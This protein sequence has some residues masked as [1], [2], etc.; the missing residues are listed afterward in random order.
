M[1]HFDLRGFAILKVHTVD[2]ISKV[3]I[4]SRYYYRH[5]PIYE[6]TVSRYSIQQICNPPPSGLHAREVPCFS[7]HLLIF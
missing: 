4:F 2:L 7:G 1:R 5:K 3:A 6:G